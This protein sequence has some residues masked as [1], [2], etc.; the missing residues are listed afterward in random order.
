[1]HEHHR[2][3]PSLIIALMLILFSKSIISAKTQTSNRRAAGLQPDCTPRFATDLYHSLRA[4]IYVCV[5]YSIYHVTAFKISS[6]KMP[7]ALHHSIQI[8][9]RC[10]S[11]LKYMYDQGKFSSMHRVVLSADQSLPNCVHATTRCD[12]SLIIYFLPYITCTSTDNHPADGTTA[13][14]SMMDDPRGVR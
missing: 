3:C 11:K 12:A 9:S 2:L 5:H 6:F 14:G 8:L 7:D 13:S 10:L 1:M 4:R